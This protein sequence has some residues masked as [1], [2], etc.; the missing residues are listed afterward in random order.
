M[1]NQPNQMTWHF[2]GLKSHNTW[3]YFLILSFGLKTVYF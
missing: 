1:N 2:M 3:N